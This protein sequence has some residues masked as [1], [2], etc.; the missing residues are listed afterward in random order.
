MKTLQSVIYTSVLLL[1][2]LAFSPISD[3]HVM[4]AQ[5]GSLNIVDD[6][7]FMVISLP[8]T[9]FKNVDDDNDGKLSAEEFSLH[10]ANI[11]STVHEKITL[12]EKGRKITLQ[13][14][15]LAPVTS[16]HSLQTPSSQLIVMGRYSLVSPNNDLQFEIDLFGE[17]PA[18]QR[19]EITATKKQNESRQIIKLSPQQTNVSLFSN[20]TLTL[21]KK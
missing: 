8:V 10:R 5:H 16:H 18:E 9:A 20:E 15:M 6:G 19:I 2:N 4:V 7:V 12:S 17:S 13:G 14:M 3:A 11:A 21:A 1:V